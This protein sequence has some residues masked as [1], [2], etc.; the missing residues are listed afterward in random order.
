MIAAP[1]AK[2]MPRSAMVGFIKFSMML[3]TNALH[4]VQY[5]GTG[6]ASPVSHGPAVARCGAVVIQ[7]VRRRRGQSTAA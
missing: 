3:T 6:A 5:L 4:W 7:A 1:E 2:Q